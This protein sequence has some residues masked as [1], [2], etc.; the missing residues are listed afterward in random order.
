MTRIKPMK[1]HVAYNRGWNDY[2]DNNH[3]CP[4]PDDSDDAGDWDEGHD[5]AEDA[6]DAMYEELFDDEEEED[7]YA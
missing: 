4:F 1:S 6:E 5:D 2:L 3:K 7:Y